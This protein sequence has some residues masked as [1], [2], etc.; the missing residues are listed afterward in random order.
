MTGPVL[1]GW[2]IM[3]CEELE[4]DW[5]EKFAEWD[6]HFKGEQRPNGRVVT[7]HRKI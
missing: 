5:K 1:Q 4:K 6:K 2:E 3:N 7:L